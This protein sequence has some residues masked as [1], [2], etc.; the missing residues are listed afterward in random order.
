MNFV[1]VSY[2]YLSEFST[3][4]SWLK[5]IE[6]YTGVYEYLAK[7]GTVHD[8]KQINYEGIY[9]QKDVHYHFVR[10]KERKKHFSLQ[11]NQYV[12][13]L[14]PDIVIVHGL[15]QP[16]QL[17]QLRLVLPGSVKIMVQ[18][19][20]EK[21]MPGIKKYAQRLA[22]QG[23]AAYLFASHGLGADWVNK[24]NLSS[25]KKIY[26]VMEVSSVFYP[27]EKDIAKLKTG[28]SS[29]L[30]FLWVGRLNENKD[31]INVVKAF[32]KFAA[33][34][35]SARLY[36]IYHTD[37]LLRVIKELINGHPQRDAIVMI[38][39]IPHRDLL[40]W[41]N[42]A[43]FVLSGSFYEGSG[44]A[45]CE[46]MSCGCIPIV[47]DI[48]SFRMITDQGKCGI[49]YEAGSEEALLTALEELRHMDILEK[50]SLC[51]AYF[52]STL[53]FEAIAR[54]IYDIAAAL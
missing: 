17:I 51:L 54:Q 37:E 13:K 10:F 4:E 9:N 7:L 47:T 38:G 26:E 22:D 43:D 25:L 18:H 30:V 3:P 36:M 1:F 6:G 52:Q 21:P 48:F 35:P 8:V 2:D 29:D 19:H 44:T 45:I 33:L 24:G 12:K 15:H 11:I 42:R 53:S 39:Q 34:E 31:P 28:V 46:A 50:Q 49:L 5:R 40:Y 20:A 14:N 32:L 27:I 41:F 16:L 23:V